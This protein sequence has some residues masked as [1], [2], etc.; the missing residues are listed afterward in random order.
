MDLTPLR[1]VWRILIPLPVPTDPVNA[2]VMLA[3]VIGVFHKHHRGRENR[4]YR[5]ICSG[6]K[7]LSDLEGFFGTRYSADSTWALESLDFLKYLESKGEV[8]SQERGGK[9]VYRVHRR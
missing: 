4:V 8:E 7:P 9:I 5:A 3:N 1:S 2:Y 6:E